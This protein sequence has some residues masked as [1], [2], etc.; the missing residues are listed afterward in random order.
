MSLNYFKSTRTVFSSPTSESSTFVFKLFK[1]VGTLTSLLMCSLS[2]S[3]FKAM[4]SFLAAK[5]DVSMPVASS[6]SF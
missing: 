6:N 5:L 4:K 2:T 1:L 3:A